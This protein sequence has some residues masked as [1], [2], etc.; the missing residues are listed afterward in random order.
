MLSPAQAVLLSSPGISYLMEELY[1]SDLSSVWMDRPGDSDGMWAHAV[2]A[3]S[4][5]PCAHIGPVDSNRLGR[6][7]AWARL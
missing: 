7:M 6:P 3:P 5:L 2:L 1:E 4:I